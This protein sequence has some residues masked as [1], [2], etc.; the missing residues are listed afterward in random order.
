MAWAA[1]SA[2]TRVRV[3]GRSVQHVYAPKSVP[4]AAGRPCSGYMWAIYSGGP[5]TEP[6]L[7]TGITTGGLIGQQIFF[8][9][10]RV[11]DS[12]FAPPSA[13]QLCDSAGRPVRKP[14]P[15]AP[16]GIPGLLPTPGLP[17]ITLQPKTP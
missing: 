14:A 12:Q 10:K 9:T 2:R 16:G 8:P 5:L 3:D 7:P 6:E 17:S 15:T 1:E 4:S 13:P 11:A